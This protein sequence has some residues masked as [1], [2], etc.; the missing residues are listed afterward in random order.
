MIGFAW[1]RPSRAEAGEAVEQNGAEGAVV[2]GEI[3]DGRRSRADRAGSRALRQRSRSL[4]RH[5]TLKENSTS[6]S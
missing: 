4:G 1:S 6:A 5:S 2:L 3:V